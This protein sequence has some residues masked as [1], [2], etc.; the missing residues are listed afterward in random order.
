MISV[1]DQKIIWD[2]YDIYAV[3]EKVKSL[4]NLGHISRAKNYLNKFSNNYEIEI[5]EL[6]KF[7]IKFE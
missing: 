1:C 4:F 2:Y 6:P 5:G 3:V 7:N